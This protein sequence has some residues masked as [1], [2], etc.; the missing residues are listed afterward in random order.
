MKR[1]PG[2]EQGERRTGPRR[3]A[4]RPQAAAVRGRGPRAP[5]RLARSPHGRTHLGAGGGP[6]A[7]SPRAAAPPRRAA[8]TAPGGAPEARSRPGRAPATHGDVSAPAGLRHRRAGKSAVGGRE[9]AAVRGG[10]WSAGGLRR[11][12]AQQ[13]A[14]WPLPRGSGALG[15]SF[16]RGPS[17]PP[18]GGAAR[19][20]PSLTRSHPGNPVETPVVASPHSYVTDRLPARCPRSDACTRGGARG[21]ENRATGWRFAPMKAAVGTVSFHPH[22][23]ARGRGRGRGNAQQ[24][25]VKGKACPAAAW[26]RVTVRPALQ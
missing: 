25:L 23:T 20:G 15:L 24:R 7:S 5:A 26:D 8:Q 6:S 1:E 13:P 18:E 4:V 21:A 16:P 19:R 9:A 11:Q 12:R 3:R 2:R 22:A 17:H 14:C 10:Q